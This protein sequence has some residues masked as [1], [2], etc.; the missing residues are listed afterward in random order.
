MKENA[1]LLEKIAE[2][3][4]TAKAPTPPAIVKDEPKPEPEKPKADYQALFA[5]LKDLGLA[6]FQNPKFRETLDAVKA[7]GK[8]AI[9]HLSTL[10]KTSA[11]ATERFLAAALLEGAA[12]P[13]S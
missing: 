13:S 7:S 6:A 10:L 2:L 3:E 8:P 5:Q 11:S 12:D 1:S 4:K 9:E